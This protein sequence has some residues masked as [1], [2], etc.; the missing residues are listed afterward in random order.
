MIEIHVSN[1]FHEVWIITIH[2]GFQLVSK[3]SKKTAWAPFF[4]N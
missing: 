4:T 1:Q 2:A 3:N